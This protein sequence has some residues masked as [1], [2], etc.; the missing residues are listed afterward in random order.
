MINMARSM[1]CK[2]FRKICLTVTDLLFVKCKFLQIFAVFWLFSWKLSV[3]DKKCKLQKWSAGQ[4]LSTS[5][6]SE[7]FA[8]LV[9]S[10][11]SLYINSAVIAVAHSL[12]L[13]FSENH[14][15]W[16][17]PIRIQG[18]RYRLLWASCKIYL[19]L[20]HFSNEF[21]YNIM[22]IKTMIQILLRTTCFF[23]IYLPQLCSG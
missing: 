8:H 17:L 2:N 3:L 21:K 9:L 12:T 4:Y 11:S 5:E 23:W 16:L 18:E 13:S 22:L 15:I 6:I 19:K 20:A 14:I 1:Y 10:Y 7:I